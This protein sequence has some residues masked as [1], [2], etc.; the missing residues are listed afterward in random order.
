MG[1]KHL[2][3]V[4]SNAL[5]GREEEYGTWYDDVHIPDVLKVDGVLTGHRYQLTHIAKEG[6]APPVHQFLAVYELEGDP[7]EIVAELRRRSNT[8]DMPVSDSF[9]KKAASMTIFKRLT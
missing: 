1:D 8:P 5:E 3:C 4:Y 2:I 6:A 9:D 7:D